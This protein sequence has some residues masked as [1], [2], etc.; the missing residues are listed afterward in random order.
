MQARIRNI[1]EADQ[2][3][4]KFA[5]LIIKSNNNVALTGDG[6]WTML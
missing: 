2:L 1:T 5:E 4:T 6:M 3:I